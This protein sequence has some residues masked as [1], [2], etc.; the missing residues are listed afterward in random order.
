MRRWFSGG[1]S[2]GQVEKQL[3]RDAFSQTGI[4]PGD[5]MW[6][7]KEAFSDGVSGTER[8]WFEE[9]QSRVT[10]L[11]PADWE[12]QG[13]RW[14]PRPQT[15]EAYWYRSLYEESYGSLVKPWPYWMPRWSPE[16]KDPSARTLAL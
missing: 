4:L 9:I 3:L 13:K 7:K 2:S 15:A 14:T 6:R 5:V 16:T 8:S 1:G 11:V 12:E 10:R